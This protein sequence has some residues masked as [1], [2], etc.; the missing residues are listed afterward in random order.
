MQETN[1]I[2]CANPHGEA[3]ISSRAQSFHVSRG[4]SFVQLVW[5][6]SMICLAMCSYCTLQHHIILCQL[7]PYYAQFQVFHL[8]FFYFVL[9]LELVCLYSTK[10]TSVIS[11]CPLL[12]YFC[13]V[14]PSCL[15]TH[16][17]SSC[18]FKAPPP[19]NP[20]LLWLVSSHTPDQS[21]PITTDRPG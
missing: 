2:I 14:P 20:H 3:W 1:W 7:A 16:C 12:Y 19:D 5:A 9:L 8:F 11:Y 10:H 6:Y 15:N 21:P 18:L 4:L 13:C 17:Y